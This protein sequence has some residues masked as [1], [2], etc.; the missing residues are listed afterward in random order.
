MVGE[1]QFFLGGGN[2]PNTGATRY[3]WLEGFG[4]FEDAVGKREG[5]A[6]LAGTLDAFRVDVGTAP[7]VG[8]SWT[9]TVM[10]NGVATSLSVTIADTDT[11]GVDVT[12]SVDVAPGDLL[13]IRCVPSGTPTGAGNVRWASRYFPDDSGPRMWLGGE[14]SLLH[15]SAVRY[16]HLGSPGNAW[17]T[18]TLADRQ[19]MWGTVCTITDLY[20]TLGAAPGVGDSYTFRIM[21]NGVQQ[22][23]DV[24]IADAAT[25][26]S[27]TGM[28]I[29]IASKDMVTLRC[30][31]SGTP[32]TTGAVW[33]VAYTPTTLGQFNISGSSGNGFD[34]VATEFHAINEHAQA[35][36]DVTE[37]T[38]H[39]LASDGEAADSVTLQGLRVKLTSAPSAGDS[40]VLTIRKNGVDT[41]LQVT[42]AD[43]ETE[44][45]DDSQV[46]FG[47]GDTIS[48][49]SEI[50]GTPSASGFAWWTFVIA[51]AT[52]TEAGGGSYAFI[53]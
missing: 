31:P 18:A 29:A 26:G 9:F 27:A 52:T 1:A 24:T 22:G 40:R 39:G 21:V 48:L 43:A 2:S 46:T 20:V 34:T 7:G 41:D 53:M 14:Q 49:E 36:G 6:S 19:T 23:S 51:V 11:F 50:T 3:H 16:A 35:S 15:G 44:G 37:S 42:I 5:V 28:S 4:N 32:D 8:K 45:A 13:A 33:G 12:N 47:F 38:R 17:D 25:S 10:L 30:T